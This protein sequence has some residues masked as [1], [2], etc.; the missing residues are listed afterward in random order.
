MEA[1]VV[2]FMPMAICEKKPGLIPDEF[3]LEASDGKTP[4]ILHISEEVEC[5]IYRGGEMAPFRAPIKAEALAKDIVESYNQSQLYYAPDAHPALF[6]VP[7]KRF[8]Q[9]I[10]N[11]FK[12][13]VEN[14]RTAHNRWCL[15]LI[16]LA[17][18]DW[19]KNHR[20]KTISDL[21]RYAARTLGLTNKEWYASP[22][23]ETLIECPSCTSLIPERAKKCKV[24]GEFVKSPESE[25][26]PAEAPK[27]K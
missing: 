19:N 14:A 27:A 3:R 17:D 25:T 5:P 2:S 24:C 1:T 4:S 11:N 7:G 22:T 6:W 23:P 15:Q 10:L 16:R 9:D 20:H 18:D 13:D 21:Q 12:T 8:A 26:K